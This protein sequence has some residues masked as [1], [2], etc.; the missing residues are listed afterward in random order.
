MPVTRTH[1]GVYIEEVRSSV[2]TIAGVPTL[3]AAFIGHG[4]R[5]PFYAPVQINGSAD[6]QRTFDGSDPQPDELC[7]VSF[8]HNGGNS[9]Q[10]RRA[11]AADGSGAPARIFKTVVASAAAIERPD[12]ANAAT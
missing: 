2:H 5:V 4:D 7:H 11:G 6:Y 9:T 12:V 8:F 3:A 10:I 1:P